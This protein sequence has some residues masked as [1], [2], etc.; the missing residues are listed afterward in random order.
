MWKLTFPNSEQ[1][2]LFAA[3]MSLEGIDW[4]QDE[5][6]DLVLTVDCPWE[7][8]LPWIDALYPKETWLHEVL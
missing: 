8:L 3:R 1:C 2:S 4:V 6:N 7:D 5:G